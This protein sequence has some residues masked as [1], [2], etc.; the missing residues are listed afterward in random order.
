MGET[1]TANSI[2]MSFLTPPALIVLEVSTQHYFLPPFPPNN[3]SLQA[4]INFLDGV[5]DGTVP[6]SSLFPLF[7]FTLIIMIVYI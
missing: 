7:M 3:V 2:T 4:F 5:R 1:E 6:V